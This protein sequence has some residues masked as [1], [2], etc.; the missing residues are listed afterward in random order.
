MNKTIEISE[1]TYS[2]LSEL[3]IGF[4][5]PAAVIERLLDQATGKPETKPELL[6]YPTDEET[7]KLQLLKN[8]EAEIVT[9]RNDGSREINHWKANRFSPTSSLK[10]NIWSGPLRGWKEKGI[11][12]AE[13]SILPQTLFDKD[14]DDDGVR[15]NKAIALECQLTYEEVESIEFDI[16]EDSSDDGLVYGHVIQF[17]DSND[18]EIMAKIKGLNGGLSLNIGHI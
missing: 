17:S 8:K 13:F 14:G 1:K 15:L 10:G 16:D 9:Y 12:K 18:P 6:F 5:T 4:D 2:R 11:V 7:F 3:A